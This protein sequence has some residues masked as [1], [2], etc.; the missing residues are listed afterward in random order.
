V[1]PAVAAAAGKTSI[2]RGACVSSKSKSQPSVLVVVRAHSRRKNEN[3]SLR[4]PLFQPAT[5]NFIY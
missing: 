1:F 5:I 2:L 4:R 3:R